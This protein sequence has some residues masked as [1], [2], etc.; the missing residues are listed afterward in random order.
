MASSL[1]EVQC[2]TFNR[3]H[4]ALFV[5]HECRTSKIT[6]LGIMQ[7]LVF[8]Y[9]RVFFVKQ[10]FLYFCLINQQNQTIMKSSELA[11]EEIFE[12]INNQINTNDPPETKITF[13]RLK[14]QGF[15]ESVAKQLIGQCLALE[16]FNL[17]KHKTPYD[18]KRYVTN[19]KNLPS[20]PVE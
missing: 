12:I 7:L 14:N 13:N 19:L 4:I 18:D 2:A 11:R 5:L 6:P 20:D 9:L 1:Y 16:I 3:L 8:V 10:F 17:L 15:S